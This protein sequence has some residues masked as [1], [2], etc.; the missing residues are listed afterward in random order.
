MVGYGRVSVDLPAGAKGE[1]KV[2]FD[3]LSIHKSAVLFRI[4]KDAFHKELLYVKIEKEVPG[5]AA[6]GESTPPEMGT[7]VAFVQKY[8][9]ASNE[10]ELRTRESS[11]VQADA[12]GS[13]GFKTIEHGDGPV[14]KKGSPDMHSCDKDEDCQSLI[15]SKVTASYGRWTFHEG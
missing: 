9:I 7:A 14:I 2:G 10:L 4:K 6:M 1:L 8:G 13:F 5:L 3:C 11:L 15:C 12:R